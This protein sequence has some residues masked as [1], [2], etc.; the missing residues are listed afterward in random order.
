MDNKDLNDKIRKIAEK[1]GFIKA[2]V[3]AD[4][5]DGVGIFEYKS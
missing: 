2:L 1:Y 4:K 5:S 3:V